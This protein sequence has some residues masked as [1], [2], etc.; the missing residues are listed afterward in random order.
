MENNLIYTKTRIHKDVVKK[1]R[2]NGYNH[3]ERGKDSKNAN[4]PDF[5]RNSAKCQSQCVMIDD[6]GH[7]EKPALSDRR[8]KILQ[9]NILRNSL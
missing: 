3:L 7:V 9:K 8:Q 5:S 6:V 2:E 4:H 1:L